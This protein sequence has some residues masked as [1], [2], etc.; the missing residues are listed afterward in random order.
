MVAAGL[1]GF[2]IM[3]VAGSMV[4]LAFSNANSRHRLLSQDVLSTWFG[5]LEDWLASAEYAS[6]LQEAELVR[7]SA[8]EQHGFVDGVALSEQLQ[9]ASV[10]SPR[11]NSLIEQRGRCR[12]ALTGIRSLEGLDIVQLSVSVA[13]RDSLG[14]KVVGDC[15]STEQYGRVIGVNSEG[16]HSTVVLGLCKAAATPAIGSAHGGAR[17]VKSINT[18]VEALES[19][20]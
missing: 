15:E 11:K 4:L 17:K 18:L 13:E 5:R 14:V 16:S 2:E 12:F 10:A 20:A 9:E 6:R 7:V 8:V 3:W 19:L 1:D